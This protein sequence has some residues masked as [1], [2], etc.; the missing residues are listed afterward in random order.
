MAF[1]ADDAPF[2]KPPSFTLQSTDGVPTDYLSIKRWD[3]GVIV[4]HA[5]ITSCFN[6]VTS[7][8]LIRN[9]PSLRTAPPNPPYEVNAE[10]PTRPGTP[11]QA[12]PV[13]EIVIVTMAGR[14]FKWNELDLKH[15][16][17]RA[18]RS[19]T[20]D[21]AAMCLC[22]RYDP[23]VDNDWPLWFLME[24]LV[25]SIL[26]VGLDILADG[27]SISIPAVFLYQVGGAIAASGIAPSFKAR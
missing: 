14:G 18:L 24:P 4:G 8:A 10:P 3:W 12:W 13:Q 19:F 25:S 16:G 15:S 22:T 2:T 23:Q 21:L 1:L 26:S 27:R 5:A 17:W 20:A 7:Q 11:T 9:V 6:G